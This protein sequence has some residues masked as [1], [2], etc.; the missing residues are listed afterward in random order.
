MK[1]Q[2]RLKGIKELKRIEEICKE[3]RK[4]PEVEN[5]EVALSSDFDKI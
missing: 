1:I 4:I 3:I 2:L 5:I